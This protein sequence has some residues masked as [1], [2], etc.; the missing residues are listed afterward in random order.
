MI[1]FQQCYILTTETLAFTC[2][3]FLYAYSA[4]LS[5]VF[6]TRLLEQTNNGFDKDFFFANFIQQTRRTDKPAEV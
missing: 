6:L 1:C 2:G 4:P 3:S 5:F